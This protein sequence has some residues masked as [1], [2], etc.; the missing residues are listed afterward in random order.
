MYSYKEFHVDFI[1]YIC[2][3]APE[4]ILDYFFCFRYK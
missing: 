3:E 4:T 2:K 1:Q